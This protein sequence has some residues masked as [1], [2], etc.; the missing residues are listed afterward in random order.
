MPPVYPRPRRILTKAGVEE[1]ELYVPELAPVSERPAH[2]MTRPWLE[3][4]RRVTGFVQHG[5]A[6]IDSAKFHYRFSNSELWPVGSQRL[7]FNSAHPYSATT[8]VGVSKQVD[9]GADASAFISRIPVGATLYV[10]QDDD[11]D[12]W[13]EF[14]VTGAPVD[15]VSYYTIPVTYKASGPTAIANNAPVTMFALMSGGGGGGGTGDVVGPGSATPDAIAV[16]NGTTGKIIKDGL[17][18]IATVISDAVSAAVATILPGGKLPAG[19]L[20]A[21]VALKD[22]ANTFTQNQMVTG[23]LTAT[24]GL[25]GTPLDAGNLSSGTVPLARLPVGLDEVF[26]GTADPGSAFELWYDTD[27]PNV[28][29]PGNVTGPGSSVNGDL[30]VFS[31]TTGKVLQDTGIPAAQVARLD[32]KNTFTSA[33]PQITLQH[34]VA[35]QIGFSETGQPSGA[36]AWSM[37]ANAQQLAVDT[38]SDD[39]STPLTQ[40]LTMTRAGDL[41]VGRDLYEKGRTVP[42]G[43]AIP[44]SYNAAYFATQA[45]TWTV[46]QVLTY[47]Y[48]LVGKTIT[49]WLG[50]GSH[51]LSVASQWLAVLLPFGNAQYRAI[52]SGTFN[53]AAAYLPMMVVINESQG[54]VFMYRSDFP[55]SSFPAG[56]SG[57]LYMTITL[58]LM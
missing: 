45:G 13:A 41:K 10:Q 16:Y 39:L 52:G 24:G 22:A 21:N 51:S 6:G 55:A 19:N 12:R 40:I 9:G 57:A 3:W 37:Y 17:K 35:P 46:S 2:L 58:S 29:I 15:A 44:V 49:L 50:L 14:T 26:I 38:R 33:Y 23:V 28:D 34:S 32:Q 27:E 42:M 31:G 5:S 43:H 30:A 47:H 56:A 1:V 36:R 11:S 25:D 18:T 8:T 48:T 53:T 20:P 4:C 7:Q 54:S